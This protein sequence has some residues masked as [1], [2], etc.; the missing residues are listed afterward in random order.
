MRNSVDELLKTLPLKIGRYI[1]IDTE[2]T[3]SSPND[4]II[5]IAAVEV[6]NGKL[7]GNQFNGFIKPRLKMNKRAIEVHRMNDGFYTRN[8]EMF[9]DEGRQIMI[10]F[11][12]FVRES[13]IFAHNANF[14]SEMLNRELI[15]WNLNPISM[16]RFRCTVRIFK[17]T[18]R[19]KYQKA[20]LVKCCEYFNIEK[21]DKLFHSALYDTIMCAKVLIMLFDYKNFLKYK[22]NVKKSTERSYILTRKDKSI[23]NKVENEDRKESF[24]RENTNQENYN[25]VNFNTFTPPKKSSTQKSTISMNNEALLHFSRD[26]EDAFS[27]PSDEINY[28]LGSE[29]KHMFKSE[30]KGNYEENSFG[31][32]VENDDSMMD[33]T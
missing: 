14:D 9:E 18:V 31:R 24:L 6:R 13:L 17:N 19:D 23:I 7:T 5:E 8:Y 10:S 2:T 11:L 26:Q 25:I 3:G 33:F 16:D 20:S 4:H 28:L 12:A 32:I 29:L 27:I 15:Y 22:E 1:V 21:N 30:F